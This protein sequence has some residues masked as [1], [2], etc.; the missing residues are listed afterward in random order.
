MIIGDHDYLLM[1][2]RMMYVNCAKLDKCCCDSCLKSHY[3][4]VYFDASGSGG[5]DYCDTN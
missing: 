3:H 4:V 1:L 2:M 5:V